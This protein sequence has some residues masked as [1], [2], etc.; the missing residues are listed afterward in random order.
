M[1]INKEMKYKDIDLIN[2]DGYEYNPRRIP[3]ERILEIKQNMINFGCNMPIVIDKTTNKVIAGH[4]ILETAR[5][6]GIKKLPYL[7]MGFNKINFSCPKCNMER[8]ISLHQYYNIIA[9]ISTGKCNSCGT[10]PNIGRFK[11]GL[12]PWNYNKKMPL[13]FGKKLSANK[14][15]NINISIARKGKPLS[16][17]HRS[18]LTGIPH[19]NARGK[20][21][22]NWKGG[23]TPLNH[24]IRSSLKYDIWRREVFKRDNWTCQLFGEKGYL[25]AH[26]IHNF[27]KILKENNI[28]TLNQ[29]LDCGEL[30]DVSNGITLCVDCH[31][32][33]KRKENRIENGLKKD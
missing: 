14:Q 4:L 22:H 18:K 27:Y 6:I 33:T 25:E 7:E 12:I 16:V 3:K 32:L 30:W 1:E 19:L 15:R 2:E 9:G 31:N 17:Y 28:K 21:H 5:E 23:I 26:H 24:Q 11:K 10:V 20:N 29:A 13:E 8:D